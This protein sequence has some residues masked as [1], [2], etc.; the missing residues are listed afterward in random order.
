[1]AVETQGRISLP[2]LVPCNR[3]ERLTLAVRHNDARV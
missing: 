2:P 3:S 1:M